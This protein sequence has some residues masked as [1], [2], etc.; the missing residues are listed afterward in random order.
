[1][2]WGR[3]TYMQNNHSK[4]TFDNLGIA[5]N[6]LN[7]LTD[8]GYS[9]PTP[10]QV[11]AIPHGIQGKDLIGIAQTGTGKTLAFTVPALQQVSDRKK[12]ALVVAPTRE[13]ALQIHETFTKI[14]KKFGLR[15]AVL[16][17][18]TTYGK[19]SQDLKRKPHVIIATPG[20]II[21]FVETRGLKLDQV[22]VVILDEADQMLDMGFMPQV[23]K[24]LERVPRQRQTMLFSATMPQEILSL[25]TQH[26]KMPVRI[27]VAPQGT[28]A[29]K[30]A[31]ELFIVK[32]ENKKLLLKNV[33]DEA[34]GRVLVFTRTKHGAKKI[35]RD[36]RNL[37]H[38]AEELHSN[39][40]LS[41]R[42]KTL[43]RFKN[44]QCQIVVA[45]DIAA[46]GIDV[47]EIEWVINFDLPTNPN[48]Y[49]HRIGRTAR[50]GSNG[51]ALSFATPDQQN[52]VRAIERI[53]R[54]DI[55]RA[56][57]EH[58]PQEEF[59]AHSNA[60]RSRGRHYGNRGRGQRRGSRGRRR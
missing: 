16:I 20:R 30:V 55:P 46:R 9:E 3:A 12:Q 23:K 47:S 19:Q 18:G 8:L 49:V 13:L 25:A 57:S 48:D 11:Q 56:Q 26:M 14:G 6:L 60:S 50:A 28:P 24:I 53:I 1:M 29:E 10:I 45:T 51:K 38:K 36:L 22:G 27:E 42:T 5:T 7:A 21:D 43:D 54:K 15:T 41:Q 35:C 4:N 2:Y 40:T 31:H 17:G 33:L 34:T 39:R 37:G 58:A 32:K 59:S 52:D 44:G